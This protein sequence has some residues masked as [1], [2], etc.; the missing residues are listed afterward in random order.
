MGKGRRKGK[1]STPVRGLEGRSDTQP[2]GRGSMKWET[3]T[4]MTRIRSREGLLRRTEARS[5]RRVPSPSSRRSNVEEGDREGKRIM[6]EVSK[7]RCDKKQQ[8]T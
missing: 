4:R 3:T 7:M 5:P 6:V 2:R 1:A 8:R